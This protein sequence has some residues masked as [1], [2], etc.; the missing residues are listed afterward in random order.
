ML[1]TKAL[2]HLV[3]GIP[4]ELSDIVFELRSLI[5]SAAPQACEELVRG[6]LVYFDPNRGGHV[7]A[8]I[9]QI[10]IAHDQIR[11]DF[12]HGA[13]LPDPAGL[14]S[15]KTLAKRAVTIS[16]YEDAPWDALIDLIRAAAAFDPRQLTAE[17]IENLRNSNPAPKKGGR[18]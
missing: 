13:F 17:Q 12:V 16:S 15:G 5:A 10:H 4:T 11:L 2:D 7:S 6:S 3:L 8:G 1:P 18:P 14:L 9:C